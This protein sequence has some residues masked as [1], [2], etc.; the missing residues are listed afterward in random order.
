MLQ[1][2]SKK[3]EILL[4][5]RHAQC[6]PLA[7]CRFVTERS[8]GN[9]RRGRQGKLTES[10]Y[11]FIPQCWLFLSQMC[12]IFILSWLGI[13]K[14]KMYQWLQKDFWQFSKEF[15]TLLKMS[16]GCSGELWEL[17]KLFKS[18]NFSLF[19]LWH[20]KV[21]IQCHHSLQVY[22]FCGVVD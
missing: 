22:Y 13:L 14:I 7:A 9:L 12:E 4:F 5:F 8:L 15:W 1:P 2:W 11:F 18:D 17:P 6:S 10:P 19:C 16:E 21:V 3:L 20:F